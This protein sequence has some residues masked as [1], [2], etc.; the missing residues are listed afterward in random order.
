VDVD[1]LL[2]DAILRDNAF[3]YQ[4]EPTLDDT[5]VRGLLVTWRDGS[6]HA[7]SAT[8]SAGNR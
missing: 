8:S 1:G 6:H 7:V 4:L 3:H 5:A 2:Y